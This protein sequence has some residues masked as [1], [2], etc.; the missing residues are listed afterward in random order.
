MIA[1]LQRSQL[2]WSRFPGVSVPKEKL[3]DAIAHLCK[4]PA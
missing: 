4:H 1:P 2:F 3:A